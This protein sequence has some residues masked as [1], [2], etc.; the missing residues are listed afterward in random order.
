MNDREDEPELDELDDE[1]LSWDG[2]DDVVRGDEPEGEVD[3]QPK[4]GIFDSVKEMT[5]AER[6]V[7]GLFALVS[8]AWAA[9][10]GVIVAQNPVVLPNVLMTV[11]YEFGEFLAIVAAPLAMFTV[12]QLADRRARLLWFAGA[13]VVTFPWPLFVE[14]LV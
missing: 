1:A 4:R 11:M 3:Q 13:A 8:I 14:G 2:D 5:G 9:G 12:M 10:W 7:A 6:I